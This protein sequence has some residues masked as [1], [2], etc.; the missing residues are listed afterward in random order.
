MASNIAAMKWNQ[1]KDA[2]VVP[3]RCDITVIKQCHIYKNFLNLRL[4]TAEVKCGELCL[5]HVTASGEQT[6]LLS[7]LVSFLVD[8]I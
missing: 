3:Q 2:T 4:F 5:H 8:F 6:G 7:T 1:K